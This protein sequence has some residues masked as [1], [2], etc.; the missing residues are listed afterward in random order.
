MVT[1][2]IKGDH[3]LLLKSFRIVL[4]N[5]WPVLKEKVS[6]S[7]FL[8]V[9]CLWAEEHQGKVF[10][11]KTWADQYVHVS[12]GL[13]LCKAENRQLKLN[14]ATAVLRFW[15]FQQ[16]KTSLGMCS[17]GRE[18]LGRN[19]IQQLSWRFCKSFPVVGHSNFNVTLKMWQ[20]KC[21]SNLQ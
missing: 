5:F 15:G 20:M 9:H 17:V 11:V 2:S 1:E 7:S 18:H 14:W 6:A 21:C 13:S 8:W 4:T 19:K 10:Q 16:V 12:S 3:C